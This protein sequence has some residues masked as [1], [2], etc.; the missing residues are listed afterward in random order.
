VD[1]QHLRWPFFDPAHRELAEG[2][3]AWAAR[4]LGPWSEREEEDPD[5]VARELVAR[6]GE[7]GWL[8]YCVPAAYGGVY[9]GLDV[10]SLC[11]AREVLAYHSG[12]AD[13]A[14]A[15]Q[16]LG[17]API[18][19]FGSEE[20][21]ARYLPGVAR[22]QRVAAFALSEPQAGSDVAAVQASAQRKPG[23]YVLTG[24][25]TW[26]SNAGLAHHYVVF[27][28]TGPGREG[29]SA[30]VVDAHAPGLAVTARIRTLS[31]HPLGTLTLDGCWVPEAQR[32]GEEGQGFAIAM[33]TL[34]V[35]RATVGA[36]ALG[37]GR[38]ALDEAARHARQRVAFGQVLSDFQLVRW[39]L[40]WM[41]T[42]LEASAL[43]V[44]RAAWAHDHGCTR[45]PQ[46][47]SMAKLY[48]TEAAQRVVDEAVQ[49]HG[50]WGVVSGSPVERLYREVRALRIYEGTSEI[51]A[52][53]V[54]REVA[55]GRQEVAR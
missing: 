37:F 8:R 29:L 7:A 4:E 35:F 39:K 54:G 50:A 55:R 24:V 13:F 12:L 3:R 18:A 45:G 49:L 52:L 22:G 15:M 17:S 31:P 44:Y 26:I 48:A 27:A 1:L 33:R 40:A 10:R 51:Q 25:K 41:A 47:S 46:E 9:P 20:L 5:G 32:L 43:L 6:L 38:R 19:L 11:L 53:V 34:D 23:G 36:A 30:F 42:E 28:R 21:R 16:G 14:F 2:L